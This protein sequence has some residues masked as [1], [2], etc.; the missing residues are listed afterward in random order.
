MTTSQEGLVENRVG[1]FHL[2]T[3]RGV[4]IVVTY[5][6]E[7]IPNV[8]RLFLKGV[9]KRKRNRKTEGFDFTKG[10]ESILQT[11]NSVLSLFYPNL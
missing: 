7:G 11:V 8:R 10:K 1:T 9:L 6:V 4:L 2:I 3:N 5:A